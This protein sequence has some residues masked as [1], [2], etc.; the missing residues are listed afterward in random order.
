[1]PRGTEKGSELCGGKILNKSSSARNLADK[2]SA[3]KASASEILRGVNLK[4]E[5]QNGEQGFV[6]KDKFSN[7]KNSALA[8]SASDTATYTAPDCGLNHERA[9]RNSDA[10]CTKKT[11]RG[12]NKNSACKN[13][14]NAV[15]SDICAANAARANVASGDALKIYM[16]PVA[17]F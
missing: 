1:M 3:S 8:S 17:K 15:A 10:V 16:S 12:A 5:A 6:S 14:V 2:I 7:F 9:E 11:A 4:H 13:S